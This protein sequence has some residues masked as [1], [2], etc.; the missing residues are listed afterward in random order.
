[1]SR[2]RTGCLVYP[3]P[4]RSEK[5]LAGFTVYRVTM[6]TDRSLCGRE[7][8]TGEIPDAEWPDVGETKRP[9]GLCPRCWAVWKRDTVN[10][11]DCD[12]TLAESGNA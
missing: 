7:A 8:D 11:N 10:H 3:G 2:R 12:D 5:W 9:A 4:T 1:M 6:G